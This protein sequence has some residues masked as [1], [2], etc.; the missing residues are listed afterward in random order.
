MIVQNI[1]VIIAVFN[2]EK[3][4]EQAILSVQNQT[5]KHLNIIVADDGSTDKTTEI[6]A[7]LCQKDQRIRL[8]K[9]EH[10]GVSATLN[11]SIQSSS[12]PYISFLDADDLWHESKLEKQLKVLEDKALQV[13]FCLVQEFESLNPLLKKT[14]Q[15]RIEALKGF[16]KSAILA[17]RR[18][19]DKFGLFDE[20]IE[21]GDFVE[22]YSR[23][24]R[25]ETPF[26]MIDEVLTFRRIHDN[27]TTK[28]S[29]KTLFLSILKSHLDERRK[30]SE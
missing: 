15:S 13:C 6:V 20:K 23:L 5:Y 2:G 14:H 7:Q 24:V 1:D 22:W 16:S 3:Y 25:A 21:I 28:T 29:S 10:R 17:D 30:K 27:N 11:T 8:L 18:V 4:I 19:F 12:A 9:L 26:Y